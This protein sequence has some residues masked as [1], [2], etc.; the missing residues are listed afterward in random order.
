MLL[1]FKLK[2]AASFIRFFQPSKLKFIPKRILYEA[3]LI[4]VP[5]YHIKLFYKQTVILELK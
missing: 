5:L 2:P 4:T 1:I 3:F